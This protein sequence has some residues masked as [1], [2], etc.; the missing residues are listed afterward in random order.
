VAMG[1][2]AGSTSLVL[3]CPAWRRWGTVTSV[4]PGTVILH[5]EA[6][7]VIPIADSRDLVRDS[8]LPDSALLVVGKDHR[9]GDPEPLKAMLEACEGAV[10]RRKPGDNRKERPRWQKSAKPG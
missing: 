6:D 2:E 9:L 7:E 5:A 1:L 10:L 8:G 3:L 4:K